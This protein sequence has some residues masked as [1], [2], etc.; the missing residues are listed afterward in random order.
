MTQLTTLAAGAAF[1]ALTAGAA[2]AADL[3]PP[4]ENSPDPANNLVEFGSGWYLRGD[5][6]WTR[7]SKMTVD[8][9]GLVANSNNRNGYEGSLGGGYVFNQWFRA[10]LTFEVHNQVKQN[11]QTSSFNCIEALGPVKDSSGT[12]VGSYPIY[13]SCYTKYRERISRAAGLINGY[14]DL[15]TWSAITPYV[16][17][18]VGAARNQAVGSAKQYFTNQTAYAPTFTD[19]YSGATF[20]EYKDKSYKTSKYSFAFALMAG[21]AIDVAP[22]IKFDVGYRYVNLGTV[23]AYDTST[24]N[25]VSKKVNSNEVRAGVRYLID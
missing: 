16:G 9:F 18:G 24:G 21:V 4:I 6:A 13:G 17:A 7:D 1:L 14:V 25:F 11:G 10:D 5:A 20:Y 12:V 15:G 2:L 19:P 23:K 8:A 3:S 22:H